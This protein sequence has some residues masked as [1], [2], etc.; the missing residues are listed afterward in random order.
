M[1]VD[2]R[3]GGSVVGVIQKT[4][5]VV[6]L[7]TEAFQARAIR[8]EIADVKAVT[9]D[10]ALLPERIKQSTVVIEDVAAVTDF[11]TT[12]TVNIHDTNLVKVRRIRIST[13]PLPTLRKS[14]AIEIPGSDEEIK[15]SAA[16]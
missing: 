15:C 13:K 10:H 3:S 12:I 2:H 11:V 6:L 5:A 4:A 8:I 16:D 7:D 9:V 1:P 14:R